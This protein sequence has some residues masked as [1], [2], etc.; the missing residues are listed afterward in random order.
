MANSSV[1]APSSRDACSQRLPHPSSFLSTTTGRKS[2]KSG[3]AKAQEAIVLS[4]ATSQ[5]IVAARSILESGGSEATALSTAKAAAQSI[6]IPFLSDTE[7][8]ASKLF[9]GR[10]KAK[11]QADIIASM[12]ILSVTN[13]SNESEG[14]AVRDNEAPTFMQH[15]IGPSGLPGY[16]CSRKKHPS[17]CES[18]VRRGDNNSTLR[19]K[20]KHSYPPDRER[21]YCKEKARHGAGFLNSRR[22]H[23]KDAG[24]SHPNDLAARYP[25]QDPI[26]CSPS[27]KSTLAKQRNKFPS[28]SSET[29]DE[30]RSRILGIRGSGSAD[31]IVYGSGTIDTTDQPVHTSTLMTIWW[32]RIPIKEDRDQDDTFRHE[33]V[34]ERVES[35][36]SANAN[37]VLRKLVSSSSDEKGRKETSIKPRIRESI[38]QTVLRA[39]SGGVVPPQW[40]AE[41]VGIVADAPSDRIFQSRAIREEDLFTGVQPSEPPS[42]FTATYSRSKMLSHKPRFR[43][44]VTMRKKSKDNHENAIVA[45]S[46]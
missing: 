17:H 5:A 4:Q 28:Y 22:G 44:W 40:G 10:R 14:S 31:Y 3:V 45:F 20:P 15:R 16:S 43:K 19:I 25:D 30:T 7:H 13:G 21:P 29:D 37:D 46:D 36:S 23:V 6:L 27:H 2:T 11:R 38:E 24:R 1:G 18:S 9:L 8:G 34:N 12:A 35:S 42:P 39:L 33:S 41:A 26:Y 32:T